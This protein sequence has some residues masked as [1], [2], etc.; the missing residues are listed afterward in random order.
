MPVTLSLPLVLVKGQYAKG[1]GIGNSD[2]K[3]GALLC[4]LTS[5]Y[6]P[7][8]QQHEQEREE[9]VGCIIVRR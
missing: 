3:P 5:L 2:G 4:T 1:M 9:V 7:V 6:L 8:E